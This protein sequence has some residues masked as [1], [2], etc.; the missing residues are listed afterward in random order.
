MQL[1]HLRS[2]IRLLKL[3][4]KEYFYIFYRKVKKI[5]DIPSKYKPLGAPPTFIILFETQKHLI[6]Y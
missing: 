6:D 4:I 3:A 5:L 2:A 1:G